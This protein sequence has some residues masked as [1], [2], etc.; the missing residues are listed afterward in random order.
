MNIIRNNALQQ[1]WWHVCGR[2]SRKD[3]MCL[4]IVTSCL[5]RTHCTDQLQSLLLHNTADTKHTPYLVAVKRWLQ[6]TTRVYSS[7]HK[8]VQLARQRCTAHHTKMYSSPHKGICS[9]YGFIKTM[10]EPS[11]EGSRSMEPSQ[12]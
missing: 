8:S 7:P 3:I 12:G 1:P 6:F 5:T 9:F 10:I 4:K 11:R 2:V